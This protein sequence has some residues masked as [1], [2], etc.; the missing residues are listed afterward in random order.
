MGRHSS[1][2]KE[3]HTNPVVTK[4]RFWWDRPGNYVDRWI[5]PIGPAL[6]APAGPLPDY[7]LRDTIFLTIRVTLA[8]SPSSEYIAVWGVGARSTVMLRETEQWGDIAAVSAVSRPTALFVSMPG[9]PALG[10]RRRMSGQHCHPGNNPST[11][12]KQSL[13]ASKSLCVIQLRKQLF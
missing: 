3:S 1:L 4:H 5:S 6:L 12:V 7:N 10:R 9:S 2:G 13:F 11:E 8:T